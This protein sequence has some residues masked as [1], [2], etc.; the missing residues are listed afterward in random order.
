M[1]E[2]T[3]VLTSYFRYKEVK[4]VRNLNVRIRLLTNFGNCLIDFWS[5]ETYD[6]LSKD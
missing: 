1:N 2:I 5:K 6:I 4:R 3:V